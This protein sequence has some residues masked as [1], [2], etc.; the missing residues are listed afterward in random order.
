MPKTKRLS[1]GF[2]LIE[3][4]V[5]IAIIAVLVALLLPAVQQAREAA[6]R[7]S[8]KNNLKQLG[9]ALHNYH[10]TF[11][12]LPPGAIAGV[13]GNVGATLMGWNVMILPN[14]DQAPLYNN[15]SAA[16]GF[17]NGNS[18]TTIAIANPTAV[19]SIASLRCPSDSGIFQSAA[20]IPATLI[21]NYPACAGPMQTMGGPVGSL[22]AA[23]FSLPNNG[24]TTQGTGYGA[25][26][27]IN[28]RR[29]FSDFTDGLSNCILIGERRTET[30]SGNYSVGGLTYWAGPMSQNGGAPASPAGS[31]G[32]IGTAF[33]SVCLL[34]NN[35]Q[36]NNINAKLAVG[37]YAAYGFGSAHV[38]GAQFVMG[39]GAVHFLSE[40]ISVGLP[41]TAGSTYQNLGTIND[42]QVLG[43]Y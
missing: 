22:Y 26:F 41:Y 3:L 37:S 4:L 2:T 35:G 19:P 23:T 10:D 9:L 24:F 33:G 36:S 8:C 14:M 27:S 7:S 31:S 42:G 6:R 43:A 16:G 28:S 12:T 21:S 29:N 30:L 18:W 17:T 15:L 34:D 5:V 1:R 25:P 11:S 39:D 20:G 40:N 13:A 32:D 38:G